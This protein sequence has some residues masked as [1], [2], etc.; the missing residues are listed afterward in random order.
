MELT[1]LLKR[2]VETES[3]SHD[4]TAV[5]RVG[6]IVAEE[7]RKLGAKVEVISNQETGD[8]VLARFLALSGAAAAVEASGKDGLLLLCHMDTVFP[9]GTLQKTP[10]REDGDKI[11]GPGTL[12]MKAGIVIALAAIEEAQKQGLLR[13]VT[14]LCTSDEE[15]GSH[16]S[17]G[18][19][20]RLAKESAL[21][22]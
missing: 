11:F 17:R 16:T 7:S 13:P 22:L 5:D 4:K 2:L 15:I 20:E 8:H 1:H 19:I 12:D 10:F 6:A 21:V 18:L 14:L 9:L 3:P